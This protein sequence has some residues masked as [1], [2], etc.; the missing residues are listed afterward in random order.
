[1]F[2]NKRRALAGLGAM[3]MTLGGP[4][5][6]V[7]ATSA[8]AQACIFAVST[9]GLGTS[10][11]CG[12]VGT[13]T[14]SLSATPSTVATGDPV[15]LHVTETVVGSSPVDVTP[16]TTFS[17]DAGSC[18]A[19]VCTPDTAGWRTIGAQVNG[20]RTNV[21]TQIAAI[22]PDR[23]VIAGPPTAAVGQPVAYTAYHETAVGAFIDDVTDLATVTLGGAAC[24][25]AVCT[26]TSAGQQTVRAT[27]SGLTAETTLVVGTGPTASL[28][29]TPQVTNFWNNAHPATFT[30]EAYDAWGNDIGDVTPQSSFAISPDGS[31]TGNLCTPGSGGSHTVTATDGPVSGAVT[32]DAADIIPMV[33]PALP[34]G[35]VGTPYS[36]SVLASGDAS[37]WTQPSDPSTL[38][39]GLTLGQHGTLSG[40][41]T[42]AGTYT[43]FVSAV[44]DNGG[45]NEPTTITIAPGTLPTKPAKPTVSI[46]D[47]SV[48]EGNH[49]RTA[50]H[51]TVTLSA[52]SST[53]VRVAWHTVNGSAV[54]GKDYSARHGTITIPAGQTTAQIT[55]YVLG[56]R[57]HEQNETFHIVL[58]RPRGATLG[59]AR[60]TVTVVNDD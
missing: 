17:I 19:N 30:A 57:R 24:P 12:G 22:T 51:V 50:V 55:V 28:V 15:T 6:L 25:G 37:T 7:L 58:T 45:Q 4:A 38:P 43:F 5:A 8:P 31:C 2:M 48:Q 60:D 20:G 33:A 54:R 53:P 36:A 10:P 1:M 59:T 23:L 49:G 32:L 3:A 26:A 42:A 11:S 47:A 41:P 34:A 27:L 16:Q 56:D 39:P 21:S 29:V 46:G 18:T 9:P 35:Q 44:N 13:A 14:Y 40:T 52:P